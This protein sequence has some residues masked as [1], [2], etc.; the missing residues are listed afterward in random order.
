MRS[1]QAG[2][3]A[4]SCRCTAAAVV[5]VVLPLCLQRVFAGPLPGFVFAVEPAETARALPLLATATVAPLAG[6]AVRRFRAWPVVLGGLAAIGLGDVLSVLGYGSAVLTIAAVAYGAGAGLAVPATLALATEAGG[7][8]LLAAWVAVAVAALAVLPGL[9]RHGA[10]G[11]ASRV[12]PGPW[13]TAVAIVSVLLYAMLRDRGPRTAGARAED[14]AAFP[15]AERA[16]LAMLAAPAGAL[17][18]IAL[19]VAHRPQHAAAAAAAAEAVGLFALAAMMVRGTAGEGSEGFAVA[20]AALGF[21]V[22]PASGALG[23]L[24]ALTHAGDHLGGG[25][26]AVAAALGAVAGAF[27]TVLRRPR[28]TAGR[29]HGTPG[30]APR[31]QAPRKWHASPIAGPGAVTGL[32]L[33]AAALIGS[34]LAG[35]FAAAP[36]LAMFAALVT[37]GLAAAVAR[38]APKVTTAGAMAGVAICLAGAGVGYLGEG[39]IQIQQAGTATPPVTALGWW[40]LA[41]AAVVLG[42]AMIR[43]LRQARGKG[44]P[45]HG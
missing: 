1:G 19:A 25:L 2:W 18:L 6:L 26:V 16:Q 8:R 27:A 39:A 3:Q 31:H 11:S 15:P 34:R 32:L 22:A 9:D 45:A 4:A 5:A 12:T 38:R 37:G 30:H 35:P 14:R 28:E 42:L 24:W 41:G 33:A 40:E 17:G 44:R 43:Y 20:C 13:L 29:S 21:I 23:S 10:A 7:R 36:L